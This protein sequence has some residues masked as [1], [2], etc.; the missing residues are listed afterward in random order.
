MENAL[1]YHGNPLAPIP[2]TSFSFSCQ[3]WTPL[4]CFLWLLL[5]LKLDIGGVLIMGSNEGL[6]QVSRLVNTFLN[7]PDTLAFRTPVDPKAMNIPDYFQ[8]VK[9]PMDL[10]TVRVAIDFARLAARN[11]AIHTEL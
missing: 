5:L 6:Q 10:G 7:R 11:T 8:I 9:N 4:S 3:W 1:T 2:R